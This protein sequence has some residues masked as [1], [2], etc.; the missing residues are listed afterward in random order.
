MDYLSKYFKPIAIILGLIMISELGFIGF[1][2]DE[3]ATTPEQ[4]TGRLTSMSDRAQ[5][6]CKV[7]APAQCGSLHDL[8]TNV[9][10]AVHAANGDSKMLV[11]ISKQL[12]ESELSLQKMEPAAFMRGTGSG[13]GPAC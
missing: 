6:S 8:T 12:D 4:L 7:V 2:D 3:R 9:K 13:V 10:T 11:A 1:K 5:A